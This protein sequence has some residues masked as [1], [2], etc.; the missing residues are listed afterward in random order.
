MVSVARSVR[1]HATAEEVWR[2]LVDVPGWPRWASQMERLEL[3]DEPF[4]LGSRVRVKPKGMR[5]AV[6][7]VTVY[8]PP[9]SFTWA[10]RLGPGA[11]L[12]GG[13]VVE[14]DGEGCRVTLSLAS[15]GPFAALLSPMLARAFRRN[16]AQ[17]TEGLKRFF[18]KRS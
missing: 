1:I 6:W 16:T 12:E 15:S 3:L 17:A 18:E 2:A 14:P 5:A 4:G 10:A 7:R 8:E 13:H 11:R 9:R